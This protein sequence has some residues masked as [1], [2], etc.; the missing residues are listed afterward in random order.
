MSFKALSDKVAVSPQISLSVLDDL[1]AQG[2]STVI[3]NRPD[4]EEPGQPA[5]AE[6]KAAAE[7]AGLEAYHVPIRP[8]QATPA[9]VDAFGK[10]VDQAEGKVLAFCKS[11][12]RS[13][14]LFEASRR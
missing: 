11:G 14:S 6:V 12:G 8:G 1:K 7:A 3:S 10:A 9:D 4:N 2:Y 13:Q 5:F